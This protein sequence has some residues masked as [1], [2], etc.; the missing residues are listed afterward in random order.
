MKS[1]RNKKA[2]SLIVDF[3]R[4]RKKLRLVIT[5]Q[6]FKPCVWPSLRNTVGYHNITFKS[7][8][9]YERFYVKIGEFITLHVHWDRLLVGILRILGFSKSKS[10][11]I[12]ACTSSNSLILVW[13]LTCPIFWRSIFE[14]MHDKCIILYMYPVKVTEWLFQIAYQLWAEAGIPYVAFSGAWLVQGW[15]F[16]G[17][18]L[19]SGLHEVQILALVFIFSPFW[20]L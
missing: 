13:I 20:R 2:Y 1:H 9:C 10:E 12:S 5:M 8:K 6:H 14:K 7:G 3:S 11:A 18:G 15:K 4:N 17:H 19:N 16:S